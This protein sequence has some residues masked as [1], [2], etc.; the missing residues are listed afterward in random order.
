MKQ[1]LA[2]SKLQ[3]QN[4]VKSV[5]YNSR[6]VWFYLKAKTEVKASIFTVIEIVSPTWLAQLVINRDFPSK[7]ALFQSKSLAN[8]LIRLKLKL[9]Q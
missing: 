9:A 6:A 2:P 7:M 4:I 3:V 1:R 5:V 8:D